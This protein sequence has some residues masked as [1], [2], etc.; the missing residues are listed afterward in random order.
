MQ[1]LIAFPVNLQYISEAMY[2][3]WS[4]DAD[5]DNGWTMAHFRRFHIR[6]AFKA[7]FIQA[8]WFGSV[9]YGAVGNGDHTITWEMG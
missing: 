5:G 6:K 4:S 9:C 1:L 2:K 3:K 8:L 7:C